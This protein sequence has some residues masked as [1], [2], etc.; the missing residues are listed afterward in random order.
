MERLKKLSIIHTISNYVFFEMATT[1]AMPT[2]NATST[3]MEAIVVPADVKEALTVAM[4]ERPAIIKSM[5][6]ARQ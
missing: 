2:N 4:N 3:I 1:D 6:M 5:A